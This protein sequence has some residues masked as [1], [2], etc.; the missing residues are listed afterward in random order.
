[1]LSV[2]EKRTNI[3]FSFDNGD[4]VTTGEAVVDADNNFVKANSS[5]K[6]GEKYAG[7]L[8]MRYEDE[9]L[10]TSLTGVRFEDLSSITDMVN[11]MTP[12]LLNIGSK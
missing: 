6:K 5:I 11:A 1:M 3:P 10:K 8:T 9:E 2:K 7:N 4:F 12:E